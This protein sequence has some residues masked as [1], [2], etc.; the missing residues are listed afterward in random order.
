[1]E[2][3][4]IRVLCV[5][6]SRRLT[7]AWARLFRLQPDLDLVG[8]LPNADT[9]IEAAGA[10][11]PDVVLMDL[12]MDGRD[13]LEAL[14][15]LSRLH[16]EVRVIICTG[17]CDPELIARVLD[18]GAWGCIRKTQEPGAIMDAIRRVAEGKTPED[19]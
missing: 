15:E 17:H 6:D 11:R 8:A 9:L 5:D 2:Q 16:P 4:R 12:T 18:A 3:R 10:Q 7:D 13:P 14:A 19:S 1:M